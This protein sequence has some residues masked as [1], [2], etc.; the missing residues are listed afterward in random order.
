MVTCVMKVVCPT[1]KTTHHLPSDD[2]PLSWDCDCGEDLDILNLTPPDQPT[3][4]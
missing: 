3:N 4:S 2:R 1:C